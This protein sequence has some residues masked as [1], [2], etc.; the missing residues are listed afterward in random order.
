MLVNE[1]TWA[2]IISISCG[3]YWLAHSTIRPIISLYANNNGATDWEIGIILGIYAF[4]PF[5]LAIPIGGLVSTFDKNKLLQIG[6][7]L[8]VVSAGLYI[9]SNSFWMLLIAQTVAGIGQLFVWLIFQVMIT[10]GKSKSNHTRIATF[11]LYMALGQL[12]GPLLG[13][14]LSD[15]FGYSAAF[16]LYGVICILLTVVSYLLKSDIKV[17]E[18]KKPDFLEMYKESARLLKNLGFVAALLFS[19]IVLFIIDA[20]MSFLPI[21]METLS[22]SNTVIGLLLSVASFSALLIKFIYP[23][24]IKRLGYMKLLIGSFSFSI[25]LLYLA[26]LPHNYFTMGILIFITGIALAINQP[27][28]LSLI[29][30]QTREDQRGIAFGMRLMGNRGAQLV[31]PL[32]FGAISSIFYLEFAFWIVAVFLTL[33]SVLAIAMFAAANSRKEAKAAYVPSKKEQEV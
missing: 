23:Y 18:Y 15:T 26:P 8:M 32:V 29:S 4:F 5:F 19:F 11:S 17:T 16:M 2:L 14:V 31:D 6:A 25:L 24:L 22:F 27:L 30:E 12:L 7:W 10:E 3:L 9:I 1:K 33:L 13:G 20:R 21:Y 28:S